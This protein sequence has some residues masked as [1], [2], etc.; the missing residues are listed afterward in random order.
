M[1]LIIPAVPE[2]RRDGPIAL[3][4]FA[5]G[6]K[7]GDGRFYEVTP[8]RGFDGL[9]LTLPDGAEIALP[10]RKGSTFSGPRGTVSFDVQRNDVIG[11]TFTPAVVRAKK[12]QN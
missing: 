6:Y 11:M 1:T 4:E 2:K 5:G 8:G 10:I 7:A 9:E 12:S 3:G